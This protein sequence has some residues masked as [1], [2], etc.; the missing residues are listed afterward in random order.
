[1]SQNIV[2]R[3]APSKLSFAQ[4]LVLAPIRFYRRILSPLKPQ[5]TCRFSPT[6]STYAAEA[7]RRHGALVGLY[8]AVRRVLKCHPFHPGG[9][10]PVPPKRLSNSSEVA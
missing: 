5:P 1:M 7:V 10:D 2:S 3:A 8:L 6:C 4:Q 9:H